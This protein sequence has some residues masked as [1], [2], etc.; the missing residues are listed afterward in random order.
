MEVPQF[1]FELF[2]KELR[3]IQIELLKKV[4]TKH[5]LNIEEV[6]ADFLPEHLKIVPN[7]KTRI[8]VKKKH[9]PAE[10]PKAEVRC[11][12]RVWNRGKGGQCM[13]ERLNNTR[14]CEY[15]SQHEKNRKHGRIDEQPSQKIF[16]Q[17][18]NAVY[19]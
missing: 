12:A 18:A 3:S 14:K 1:I 19:K 4:A 16:P 13:R 2:E 11:M 17:K 10:P 15:C 5:G 8:Q 7:T 9:A 6:V